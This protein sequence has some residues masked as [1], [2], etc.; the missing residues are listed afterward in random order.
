MHEREHRAGNWAD[1]GNGAQVVSSL[2][3]AFI[4]CDDLF[5]PGL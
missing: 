1:A 2:G 3:K 5:D 4:G